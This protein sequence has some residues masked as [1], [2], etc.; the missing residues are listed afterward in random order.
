M[1][2][3]DPFV[4]SRGKKIYEPPRFMTVAQ[5][6]DQL[7]QIIHRRRGEGE[8]LGECAAALRSSTCCRSGAGFG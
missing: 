5:A 4:S 2:S 8:E 7:M 1:R 3:L 6:A